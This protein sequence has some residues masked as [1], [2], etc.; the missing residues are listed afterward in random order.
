MTIL[1]YILLLLPLAIPIYLLYAFRTGMVRR[2]VTALIEM[3][4]SVVVIGVCAGIVASIN[5]LWVS[6]L[7]VVIMAVAGAVVTLRKSRIN[8]A[9]YII[10]ITVG[11]LA[12]TLV[13]VIYSL[14]IIDDAPDPFSAWLIVPMSGLLIGGMA[15][16]NGKALATYYSGLKHHNALYYYL[17]GNGATHN[18]AMRWF[19]KRS[20]QSA[21]VPWIRLMCGIAVGS[22]PVVMWI[23]MYF[24]LPFGKAIGL[25][26]VLVSLMSTASIASL[27]ITLYAARRYSFDEYDK[28]KETK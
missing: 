27:V 13:L 4:V 23:T 3:A 9:K 12:S 21:A 20:L 19:F 1:K 28:L 26:L 25:Q 18:E 5:K 16:V 17:I 22:V 11:S 2:V 24:G 8:N 7:T 6:L 14:F 10:P 15:C